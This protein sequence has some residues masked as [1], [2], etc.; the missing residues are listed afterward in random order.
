MSQ[1]DWKL[2]DK[3]GRGD[4]MPSFFLAETFVFHLPRLGGT[5]TLLNDIRLKYLY[6]MFDEEA[7]NKLAFDKWVFNTEA[8]PFPISKT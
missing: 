2:E 3:E 5:L 1:A 6:L 4:A 7:S 8:H